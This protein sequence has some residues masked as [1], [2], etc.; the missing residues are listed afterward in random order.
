M[1]KDKEY[2]K[3]IHTTQWLK[4]RRDV[5][6]AHPLC[7]RCKDNGRL[8]PATEVH[9]IRPVEE[10]F[11]HAERVQRMYDPHNLQALCHDCHVKVHTEMGRGG[12]DATRKRNEKQVQDIIKKFFGS[13]DD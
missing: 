12:K 9:H 2:N 11:T 4:L 5:L 6:T 7:Q 3:L 8:T 10:A 13:P 1:A